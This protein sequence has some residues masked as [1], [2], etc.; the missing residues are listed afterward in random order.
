MTVQIS[1]A[2]AEQIRVLLEKEQNKQTNRVL[3]HERQLAK[4]KQ[5]F[6]DTQK[7]KEAFR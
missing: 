7:L 4:A 6:A 1:F 2:Q 5:D 3:R